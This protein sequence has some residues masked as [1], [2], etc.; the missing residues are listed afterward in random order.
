MTSKNTSC[1]HKIK[2]LRLQFLV[3]TGIFIQN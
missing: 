1:Q 3:G 2:E